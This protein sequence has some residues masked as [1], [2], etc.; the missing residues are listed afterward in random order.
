[1]QETLVKVLAAVDRIEP[2]MLEPY[3]IATA[4][5]V[6]ASMWRQG[7]R[8]EPQPAPGRSTC[9]ARRRRTRASSRPR[10]STAM[11]DGA[12]QAGRPRA[13]TCCSPT[14]STGERH[15][16]AGRRASA[17]PP[18][19][20]RPSSS[21]PAPGCG[22]STCW[23]SSTPSRPPTGAGPC[24]WRCPAATGAAS[25]RSTPPATCWSAT[26][27]P[28]SASRWSAA[29]RSATT[30][31]HIPID[32]RRRHRRRPPGRPRAGAAGRA[33]PA[34]DLTL[35]ATAV[36]EVARNIVRFAGTRRGHDR[37]ARASRARGIRVVARDAGPGIP[38]VEQALQRRLQHLRRAGAGAARRPAA[39]G[40]VRRRLRAGRGHDRDA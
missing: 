36:S 5:N 34:T 29:D 19:R 7:D 26:C 28:G 38:D 21:A 40:R 14:R 3:A 13:A 20:S 30:R 1:M 22:W 15:P 39:D 18:A 35:I 16:D 37:A 10:S 2:G 24:C 4:R 8:D 32:A 25:A 6:V 23:R 12:G 9:S 33:S 31:S 11:A 27:A 17:P